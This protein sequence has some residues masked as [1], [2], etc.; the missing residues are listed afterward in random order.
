MICA[1]TR[2]AESCLAGLFLDSSAL[3]SHPISALRFQDIWGVPQM[4]EYALCSTTG[5]GSHFDPGS[6]P[7]AFPFEVALQAPLVSTNYEFAVLMWN[8]LLDA[9]FVLKDLEWS[10]LTV[11]SSQRVPVLSQSRMS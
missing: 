11:R 7:L 5:D 4:A 10:C 8:E 6:N 1:P 2:R 9:G 3:R